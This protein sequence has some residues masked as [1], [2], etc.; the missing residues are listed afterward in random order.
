M[1]LGSN[2]LETATPKRSDTG[3]KVG[4]ITGTGT[5]I[6]GTGTETMII[7]G[8]GNVTAITGGVETVTTIGGV[9]EIDLLAAAPHGVFCRLCLE[10][11]MKPGLTAYFSD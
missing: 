3:G 1:G 5:S 6:S 8:I 7:S 10:S 11:I 9:S 2:C 4:R